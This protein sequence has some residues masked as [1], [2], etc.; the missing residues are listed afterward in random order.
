MISSDFVQSVMCY[1][2]SEVRE[3]VSGES[4]VREDRTVCESS[5]E[6]FAIKFSPSSACVSF[7]FLALL[8]S[9]CRKINLLAI[10]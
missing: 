4:E 6:V 10:S 8:V 3:I 1:R 5:F 9:S 2:S 7:L